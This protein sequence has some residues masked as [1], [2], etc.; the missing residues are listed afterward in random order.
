MTEPDLLVDWQAL[1]RF[2]GA[3]FRGCGM[4]D[5]DAAV[6]AGSLVQTDLWGKSSHG[7]MRV[8]HYAERLLSGAVNPQPEIA[9]LRGVR[10]FQIVDGGNGPGFI[11]GRAAM[12]RAVELADEHDVGAV[13]VVNSSHFGAAALYARLAVDRGMAGIAMTNTAPKMVAPGGSRPITGSNPIAI[14]VPTHDAFP[15]L[16]DVSLSTVAGGK[17]LLAAQRGEKIPLGA[18]VDREGHPTDDPATAFA[19]YWLP[20]GG[21]KGLGLSFAVDLLAGLITGGVFGLGMKSQYSQAAQP[22]ATGHLMLALRLD[23]VIDRDE[24]HERM[25]RFIAD[26][27]A[28]PMNDDEGEMLVPGERAARSERL[29]RAEG[30]PLQPS[31]VRE[32]TALAGRLDVDEP[33]PVRG[34]SG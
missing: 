5:E 18:A 10:A 24:L 34:P 7:V 11:A 28:S 19:G 4:R 20:V 17:L 1:E 13:G 32:L 6:M 23:A 30:I 31:L 3:V 21:T 22:S 29:R 2:V 14:G 9:V 12:L 25:T 15:F 33:L 16:L 8:P 27:K 26:V